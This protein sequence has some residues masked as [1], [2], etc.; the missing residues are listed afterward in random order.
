M[1]ITKTKDREALLIDALKVHK[2]AACF[3][4][5]ERI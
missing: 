4:L 5:T 1:N 2:G 3:D